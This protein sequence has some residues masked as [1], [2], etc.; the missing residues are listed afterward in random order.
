MKFNNCIVTKNDAGRRLDRILRRM[1]PD[2]PLS[3]LYQ[4]LRKGLIRVDGKRVS[5]ESCVSEGSIIS[6]AEVTDTETQKSTILTTKPV[7]SLLMPEI[8][9]ETSDLLFVN[10]PSGIAVHGEGGLDTLVPQSLGAKESLSF[11]SGPLHRLDRDTTG[12]IAFSRSLDGAR[13]FSQGM[14]EHIFEKYYLGIIHGLL[15]KKTEWLDYDDEDKKMIT[16]ASPC[17][18]SKSNEERTLVLFKIITGRKHQIRKQ[19]S[20]HGFPLWG[21]S[22]YGSISKD[23]KFF[24]HA[25]QLHF[26]DIRMPELPSH[27]VAP[28]PKEFLSVITLDFPEYVL[29]HIESAELYWRKNEELQ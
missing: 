3:K 23:K 17:A 2:I 14:R 6:I 12:I 19:S 25:W 24:L 11:R 1:L 9:L 15:K 16:I 18:V 8:L 10:K 7:F 26:P 13:W 22:L 28:L 29:A 21:D 4:L 20:K 5:P 27:L